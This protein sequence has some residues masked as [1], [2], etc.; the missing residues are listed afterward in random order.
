MP[1]DATSTDLTFTTNV[2]PSSLLRACSTCRQVILKSHTGYIKSATGSI[3]RFDELN[4]SILLLNLS[5]CPKFQD[6]RGGFLLYSSRYANRA[7]QFSGIKSLGF[8]FKEPVSESN[9]GCLVSQ[10]KGLENLYLVALSRRAAQM[11]K[12]MGKLSFESLEEMWA[13]LRSSRSVGVAVAAPALQNCING[14]LARRAEALQ[15][16][17]EIVEPEWRVPKISVM[18]LFIEEHKDKDIAEEKRLRESS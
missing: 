14:W 9:L 1:A 18:G 10:F 7:H 5:K 2:K 15:K 12:G 17:K 8:D 11:S 4:D 6:P 3:I 16:Y 13:T